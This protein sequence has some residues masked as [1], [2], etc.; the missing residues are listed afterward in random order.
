[1]AVKAAM[2]ALSV[3][4]AMTEFLLAYAV[5]LLAHALPT[6]PPV[7]RRLVRR[8][9]ERGFQLGYSAASLALLAWLIH[10]AL[11]AP[12]VPLWPQAVWQMHLS[13]ALMPVAFVLIGI[14][15]VV[16][17]PR[18]ISL[19]PAPSGWRPRYVLRWVRHPLL[20]GLA[21]WGGLHALTNGHLVSVLLFGGLAVFALVGQA[22][23]ARRLARS[24]HSL[25]ETAGEV[26]APDGARQGWAGA[27]GLALFAALLAAHPYLFAKNP[28]AWL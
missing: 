20:M 17:N 10:A 4:G 27:L 14:G 7:R 3:D 25:G 1:M 15:L 5:F 16:A 26:A 19:W 11:A 18:S 28:L 2:A 9:G 12:Y 21:L 13:L 24:P 22:L 23:V 8:W 6:R